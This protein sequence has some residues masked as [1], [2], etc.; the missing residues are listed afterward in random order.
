MLGFYVPPTAKVI[1]RRDLGLKSRP[2]DWKILMLLIQ[3]KWLPDSSF[4]TT[5]WQ[6]LSY[7][8][9][10]PSG[11]ASSS[12]ARGPGFEP[13]DP[14][15]PHVVSLSKT[16]KNT[17]KY[18]GSSDSVPTLLKIVGRDVKPQQNQTKP[19]DQWSCKRSPD[20]LAY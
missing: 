7:G 15:D 10:L 12:R 16:K 14:H 2:K 4:M 13:H 17:D 1:W 19:E 6:K 8:A 9:R 5:T 18:L 3:G 11:R 20:I